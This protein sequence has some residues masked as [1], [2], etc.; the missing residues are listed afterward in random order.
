LSA[1][2]EHTQKL[3]GLFHQALDLS[4]P[5]RDAWLARIAADEPGLAARLVRMLADP[6]TG[7]DPF[8]DVVDELARGMDAEADDRLGQRIGD[9]E[10]DAVLGAGGM[11]HVYRAHRV[12]ADFDQI[13]A[14]KL[15]RARILDARTLMRFASERQ[16]LARLRH[17]GIAGLI[18]AGVSADGTPYLAMECVEGTGLLEWCDSRRLDVEARLRLVLELANA[19]SHA[20]AQLVV[21]L[22]IKPSNIVVTP[23]GVPKLLDFGIARMLDPELEQTRGTMTRIYTPDYASPEQVAGNALGVASDQYSLALLAYEL[24]CGRLP[25]SP[26]GRPRAIENDLPSPRERLRGLDQANRREIA[27]AR[28]MTEPRLLR[29]LGGDLAL[30]LLRALHDDPTRRYSSVE[31]FAADLARHLGGESPIGVRGAYAERMRKSLWRNRLPLTAGALILLGLG[32]WLFESA[33]GTARIE[34]E[35]DR[36]LAAQRNAEAVSDYLVSIFESADPA[37]AIGREFTAREL[38]DEGARRLADAGL[39]VL[40][41]VRMLQTLA[42]AYDNLGELERALDKHSEAA[43]QLTG[44]GTE[45]VERQVDARVAMGDLMRKL[46]R[47]QDAEQSFEAAATL[48]RTHALEGTRCDANLTANLGLLRHEQARPA[49]AIEILDRA[50]RMQL[51]LGMGN[52]REHAVTLHNLG[53]AHLHAEQLDSAA[54]HLQQARELKARIL[55][56]GHPS[57][58]NTMSVQARLAL[59]RGELEQALAIQNDVLQQRRRV[60]GEG[61]SLVGDTLNNVAGTLQDLGRYAEAETMYRQAID[62]GA[63]SDIDLAIRLNNMGTLL[64]D[65]QN[66]AG[67]ETAFRESLALRLRALPERSPQVA[68]SLHNHARA[69]YAMGDM[70]QALQQV[71]KALAIRESIDSISPYETFQSRV[72]LVTAETATGAKPS[73]P[74]PELD[75]QLDSAAPSA[76]PAAIYARMAIADLLARAGFVEAAARRL[77]QALEI[78][79]RERREQHPLALRVQA[80]R[81]VIASDD[82]MAADPQLA[83]RLELALRP[84]LAEHAPLLQALARIARRPAPGT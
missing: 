41:R 67:A 57:A 61:H 76:F 23:Q 83:A 56:E 30:V 34:A 73:Y 69:L 13:V 78:C 82:E 84:Y 70:N 28:S 42:R 64:E 15:L 32:V 9:F 14:I 55:P 46:G 50:R 20:H 80:Q 49:D 22:D 31:G 66:F 63:R 33:R 59:E 12:G 72:L 35:R 10:I 8:A 43:R 62:I 21:H 44:L 77:D 79:R 51:E 58:L 74:L 54:D 11:G 17:T 29:S 39:D 25:W 37:H 5:D 75:R 6:G 81:I 71:G 36:A 40:N 7:S 16:I 48:V 19:L 65:R 24:V 52:E 38:L 45:H 4:G 3:H 26:G 60:L 18:D 53:L 68:R 2:D 27:S 47:H 1:T